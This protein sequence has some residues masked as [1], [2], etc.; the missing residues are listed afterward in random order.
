MAPYKENVMRL[1]GIQLFNRTSD[2]K[3]VNLA[4]FHSPHSLTWS[5]ILSLS[6]DGMTR[7]GNGRIRFGIHPY[8]TNG[9]L[10]VVVA[11]PYV[12]MQWHRQRPM[13]F[14]DM[15]QRMRDEQDGLSHRPVQPTMP[16]SS[17]HLH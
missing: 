16:P 15:Y 17:L 7:K 2:R 5:W 14:R 13:W 1:F 10:Q 11:M 9:G 3:T 8:R 6:F 12:C 4:S